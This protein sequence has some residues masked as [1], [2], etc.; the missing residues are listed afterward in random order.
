MGQAQAGPKGLLVFELWMDTTRWLLERTARWPK[1]LRHSLT[2][3]VENLALE[4]LEALTSAGWSRSPQRPLAAADDALNRLRVLLRLAHELEVL[5]Y[6]HY[7]EAA[8]RLDEAGK[9]IGGWRRSGRDRGSA[10][11]SPSPGDA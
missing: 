2:L 6:G 1:R 7:E 3:R 11:T 8:R 5:S 10:S 9:M 4:T